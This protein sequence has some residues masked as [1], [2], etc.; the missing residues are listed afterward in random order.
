MC[1]SGIISMG[2]FYVILK[3]DRSSVKTEQEKWYENIKAVRMRT[4]QMFSVDSYNQ[5]L[6]EKCQI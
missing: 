3:A 5:K 6:H 4:R 2:S 1:L